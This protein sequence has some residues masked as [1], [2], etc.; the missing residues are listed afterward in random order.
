MRKIIN[1]FID[2]KNGNCFGC[3]TNNNQGLQMEFHEDGEYIISNWKPKTHL[4]GFE[5]VLHGGI[6]TTILDEIACWFVFVKLETSGV[7]TALNAKFK[8]SAF[9]DKGKLTIRAKLISKDR[10]FAN[11][12]AE[13]LDGDGNVCSHADVQYMIFPQEMAKKKFNYPGIEKFFE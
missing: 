6:Q 11:I 4:S 10:R 2:T 5:N 1:P 8:K 9:T 12:Y 7:T 13:I 3:S